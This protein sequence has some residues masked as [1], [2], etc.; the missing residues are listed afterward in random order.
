ML[1]Q[2]TLITLELD[3]SIK[4]IEYWMNIKFKS[5]PNIV[6]VGFEWKD[7]CGDL[8]VGEDVVFYGLAAFYTELVLEGQG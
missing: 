2:V 5:W 3:S 6:K 4:L 1:R 7:L 8:D